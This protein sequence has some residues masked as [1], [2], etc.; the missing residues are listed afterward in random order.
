[1]IVVGTYGEGALRAALIGSTPYKLINQ[2]DSAGARGPGGGE[3]DDRNRTDQHRRPR[4]AVEDARASLLR[5]VTKRFGDFTAVDDLSLEL[6][7]GEFFSLLGP[8]GCGKTTTLRMIAGFEQPTDG[9]D[10]A[11]GRGR[12]RR[13]RRTSADVNTVFQSYALFPHMSVGRTSPSA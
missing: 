9:E 2:T 11:R 8:S 13:R 3:S 10:P 5:D 7:R 4:P 6:G 12:R 1:M